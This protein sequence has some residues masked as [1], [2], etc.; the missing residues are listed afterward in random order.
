MTPN[1]AL[2]REQEQ[3][4]TN[5][6]AA[7]EYKIDWESD[8][9]PEPEMKVDYSRLFALQRELAGLREE[10]EVDDLTRIKK[11]VRELAIDL[12]IQQEFIEQ[13]QAIEL[14]F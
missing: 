2:C 14:E 1:I 10:P 8:H 6:Y 7:L 11:L 13:F 12:G 4:V 3:R 5:D 9:P